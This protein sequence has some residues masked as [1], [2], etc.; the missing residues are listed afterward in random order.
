MHDGVWCLNLWDLLSL[1]DRHVLV[2]LLGLDL[3]NVLLI[4]II[5][6]Y[7]QVWIILI[8]ALICH[9]LSDHPVLIDVLAILRVVVSQS[10]VFQT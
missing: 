3:L 2:D 4:L 6:N 9:T 5:S 1:G 10:V 8:L 7:L